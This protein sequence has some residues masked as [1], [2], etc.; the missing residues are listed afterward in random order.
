MLVWPLL[1]FALLIVVWPKDQH[2]IRP[3][4]HI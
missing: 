4:T 2:G 1:F 3:I